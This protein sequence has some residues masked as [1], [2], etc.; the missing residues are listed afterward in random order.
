[1]DIVKNNCLCHLTFR[2]SDFTTKE[3]LEIKIY[4]KIT[5]KMRNFLN[6]PSL[7]V[8]L[9]SS[10]LFLK[11]TRCPQKASH[12]FKRITQE[13]FRIET[14]F[15]SFA[16]QIGCR[17]LVRQK[18]FEIYYLLQRACLYL[19]ICYTLLHCQGM[20]GSEKVREILKSKK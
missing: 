7:C 17:Y 19:L 12:F 11:Y 10:D 6:I 18:Y 8:I 1:M 3:I 5:I 15:R 16:K 20:Y 4:Y 2:I 14:Q 9:S 13:I